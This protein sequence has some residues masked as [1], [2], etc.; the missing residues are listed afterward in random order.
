MKRVSLFFVAVFAAATAMADADAYIRREAWGEKSYP[1][2]PHVVEAAALEPAVTL[3]AEGALDQLEAIREWNAAGKLP[4]HGG[5]ER[6]IPDVMSVMFGPAM[7]QKGLAASGRG[8][9]ASNDSGSVVWGTKVRV[10]GAARLRL[11]LDDVRVPAGTVMWVY[12]NDGKAT[13]FDASL[14]DVNGGIWAPSVVGDTVHFEI[15]TPAKSDPASFSIRRLIQ[16]VAL[17]AVPQPNDTASC[18]VDANCVSS[19]TFPAIDIARHAIGHIEIPVGNGFVGLCT[20]G[21][22]GDTKQSGTPYFLTAAHCFNDENPAAHPDEV[23]GMEVY[24]E[25]RTPSCN[26]PNPT[27]LNKT[28]G[29][30]LLA[31]STANDYAF[32][33]LSSIPSG[34]GFLGWT[35][36][37]VAN[38]TVLNRVSHPAPS[39]LGG[40]PQPQQFSQTAVSTSAQTCTG[41][42]RPAYIYESLSTGA[43]Y[44]GSS[45][46]PVMLSDGKVVG[47]LYGKC[48]PTPNDGCD[49]ANATVDGAFAPNYDAVYKQYL[50]ASGVTPTPC[51]PSATTICLSGGRFAVSLQFRDQGQLKDATAIK[52]TDASGLFWFFGSDNIEVLMKILNACGLNNRYWVFNAATTNVEFHLKVVDT[53]TGTVKTYD[54]AAGPPA[55]A[56]TD[57][58]AFATCP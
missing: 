25:Y 10:L 53:K 8:V 14:I 16:L 7:A 17:S 55:P 1:A 45:G 57:T 34:R 39:A 9:I 51:V 33:Q 32:F 47:Q 2:A 18:L 46:S 44:G 30:Q 38:G 3:S 24:W 11:R 21:L 4:A 5:F 43:T 15:E 41:T 50:S 29:A 42:N 40:D 12:G 36:S 28:T 56:I 19:S 13:A 49:K 27:Y 26:A 54:S 35:A 6:Q 52:Y 22:L 48:G 31:S 20:G 23:S 58:G 37:P